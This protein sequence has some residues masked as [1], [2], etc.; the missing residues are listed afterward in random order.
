MRTILITGAG[1]G[2]GRAIAMHF[3]GL[4]WRV[5]GLDRDAEALAELRDALP[6][7]AALFLTADV[8]REGAVASAFEGICDA[9]SRGPTSRPSERT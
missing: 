6:R 4:D 2:I 7:E 5:I 3:H 1:N 9:I 8:G